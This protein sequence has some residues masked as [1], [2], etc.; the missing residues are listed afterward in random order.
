MTARTTPRQNANRLPRLRCLVNTGRKLTRLKTAET[1]ISAAEGEVQLLKGVELFTQGTEAD[2]I[3]FVNTGKVKVT[4]TSSYGKQAVLRILGPQ[5]F[6]GEECLV[7][8]S[9]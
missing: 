7:A 9:F 4:V 2:A 5:N 8:G 1:Y 3:F 6:L